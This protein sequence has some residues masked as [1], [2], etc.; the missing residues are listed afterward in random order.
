MKD[1]VECPQIIT[2]YRIT[3]ESLSQVVF[4][5]YQGKFDD[6]LY[7][8]YGGRET[9]ACGERSGIRRQGR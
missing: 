7:Q 1:K 5:S 9:V 8:E 4:D 6:Y 2:G 3:E